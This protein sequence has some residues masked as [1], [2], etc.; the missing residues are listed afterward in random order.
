[1][2]GEVSAVNDDKT[3]NR[4]HEPVGRFPEIE[5]DADPLYLLCQDYGKFIN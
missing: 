1:M 3:D 5:E 4:F 2:T